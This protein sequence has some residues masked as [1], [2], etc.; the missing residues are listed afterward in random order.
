MQDIEVNS[1]DTAVGT[2]IFATAPERVGGEQAASCRVCWAGAPTSLRIR[3]QALPLQPG[4]LGD[5]PLCWTE[6]TLL[7][8]AGDYIWSRASGGD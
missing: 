3:Q 4:K 8:R 6:A 5:L 2:V 1:F 7:T